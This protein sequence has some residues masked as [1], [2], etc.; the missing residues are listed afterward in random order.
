M[1]QW[2]GPSVKRRRNGDTYY[3]AFELNSMRY[4]I[5]DY[6]FLW[7]GAGDPKRQRNKSHFIA[8]ID[9]MWEDCCGVMWIEVMWYE[10][11]LPAIGDHL[12]LLL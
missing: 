10:L 6:L 11:A 8:K 12:L 2:D 3:Y 4:S 9:N 5:G 7:S 1:V